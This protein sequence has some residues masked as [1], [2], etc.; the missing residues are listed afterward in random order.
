MRCCLRAT[1]AP[2][3]SRDLSSSSLPRRVRRSATGN[4]PCSELSPSGKTGKRLTSPWIRVY[5]EGQQPSSDPA[6]CL[7]HKQWGKVVP[8]FAV[9]GTVAWLWQLLLLLCR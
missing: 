1:T 9:V 5:L 4:P 8:E 6:A 3:A 7:N 2:P